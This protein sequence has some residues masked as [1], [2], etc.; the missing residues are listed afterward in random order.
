MTKEEI[1]RRFPVDY[2]FTVYHH[3]GSR[4][5]ID[6]ESG[7]RQLLVDTYLDEDFANYINKCA[8]GYFNTA[9][10]QENGM[11]TLDLSELERKL[12]EALN[13][14]TPES[15]KAWLQSKRAN[16]E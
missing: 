9:G 4:M 14:E 12:D 5:C 13:N 10:N 8:T 6:G 2:R 15:L 1:S 3:G 7:D 16:A 11:I